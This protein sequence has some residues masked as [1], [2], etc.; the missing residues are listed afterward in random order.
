MRKI[1][2]VAAVLAIGL[3]SPM[4]TVANAATE[5]VLA[6]GVLRTSAGVP[7]AGGQ[8]HLLAWPASG[9]TEVG[10]SAAL[11]TLGAAT[12]DA[13]GHYEHPSVG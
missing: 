12:S 1:R 8:V 6:D 2:G 4:S 5:P 10:D 9:L 11:V 13:L 3:L 7:F